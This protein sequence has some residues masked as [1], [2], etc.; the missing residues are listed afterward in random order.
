MGLVGWTVLSEARMSMGARMGKEQL[1]WA[2]VKESSTL[3]LPP[4]AVRTDSQQSVAPLR[5]SLLRSDP[6]SRATIPSPSPLSLPPSFNLPGPVSIRRTAVLLGKQVT[7]PAAGAESKALASSLRRPAAGGRPA[8]RRDRRGSP[9]RRSDSRNLRVR[10]GRLLSGGSA[11][12][13]D[14]CSSPSASS[15]LTLLLDGE[16]ARGHQCTTLRFGLSEIW[17]GV[18]GHS[19]WH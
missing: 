17:F 15:A 13:L 9:P 12:H 10:H 7:S 5:C 3:Q 18:L 11:P 16:E 6:P 14:V 8:A 19:M 2:S 4:T 1:A